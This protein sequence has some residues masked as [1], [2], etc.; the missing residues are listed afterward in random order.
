MTT[1]ELKTGPLRESRF[2]NLLNESIRQSDESE[3]TQVNLD[4]KNLYYV[5]PWLNRIVVVDSVTKSVKFDANGWGFRSLESAYSFVRS[6]DRFMHALDPG[7]DES[8]LTGVD[9]CDLC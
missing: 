5:V 1:K 9:F 6:C 4:T 7:E 2:A 8:S 3:F